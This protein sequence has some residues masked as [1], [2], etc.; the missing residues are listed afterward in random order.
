MAAV[1]SQHQQINL[2]ALDHVTDYFPNRSLA[3]RRLAGE[4]REQALQH[5][6]AIF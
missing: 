6:R 4:A 3:H 5:I 2:I 1:R